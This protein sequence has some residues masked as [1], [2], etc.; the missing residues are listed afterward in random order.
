[1]TDEKKQICLTFFRELKAKGKLVSGF[2]ESLTILQDV[3][4]AEGMETNDINLL[5]EIIIKIDFGA[6]KKIALTQC[7]IPKHRISDST[8]KSMLTWCLSSL[9]ELPITDY[10]SFNL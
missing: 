1:M 2:D 6:F 5:T 3:A 9:N 4:T 8:V 10:G 7:L